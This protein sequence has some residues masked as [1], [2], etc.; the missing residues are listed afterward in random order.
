MKTDR[1]LCELGSLSTGAYGIE[2]LLRALHVETIE[3]EPEGFRA[4]TLF[5][6]SEYS[7]RLGSVTRRR[8]GIVCRLRDSQS[9]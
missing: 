1:E 5:L 3:V 9:D 6:V 2:W 8:R 4:E 7:Q